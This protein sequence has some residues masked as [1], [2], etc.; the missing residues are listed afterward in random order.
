MTRGSLSV[1][2]QQ[3]SWTG[4]NLIISVNSLYKLSLK[5]KTIKFGECYIMTLDFITSSPAAEYQR[6]VQTLC[7]APGGRTFCKLFSSTWFQAAEYSEEEEVITTNFTTGRRMND[8]I[9]RSLF[10]EAGWKNWL[11]TWTLSQQTENSWS[12]F[13]KRSLTE[14]ETC[15]LMMFTYF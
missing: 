15:M 8:N 13:I 11:R 6:N 10:Q 4:R 1:S 5:I 2:A 3:V 7:P 14:T 9:V 12:E